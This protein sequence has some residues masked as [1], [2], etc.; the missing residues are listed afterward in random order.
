MI[1]VDE[2]TIEL[3]GNGS[4]IMAETT[5]LLKCL[6]DHKLEMKD[7]REIFKMAIELH[8]DEIT[9]HADD[10]CKTVDFVMGILKDAEEKHNN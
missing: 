7:I 5:I 4:Q 10:I 8:V 3:R 9:E 1:K 6:M 2:E